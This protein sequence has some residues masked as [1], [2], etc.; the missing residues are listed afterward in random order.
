MP[1]TLQ[2][3]FGQ[4][5]MQ[6]AG[7]E[8]PGAAAIQTITSQLPHIGAMYRDGY[9]DYIILHITEAI[10]NYVAMLPSNRAVGVDAVISMGKTFADLPEV[11]HLSLTELKTFFH[12][13]FARQS[14]GK[15]YGGFGYD[16]LVEWLKAYMDQRTDA[17]V[18]YREQ[19]HTQFTN[20][21]K[22]TRSRADGDAWGLNEL[23]QNIDKPANE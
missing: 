14:F 2:K 20:T 15:L 6:T 5:W 16:T 3:Q 22:A 11:R 12:M 8:S 13:A 18:D 7:K 23:I 10:A 19:M 9:R 21:E 4:V 17:I 1:Q